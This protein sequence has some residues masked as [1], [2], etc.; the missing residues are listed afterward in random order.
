MSEQDQTFDQWCVV[1]LMGHQR[2]AGRIR[3]AA[4]PAG[5]VR[6]DVPATDGHEA[7]TQILNPASV[8]R[9][10]PTTEEIA[11]AVAANCRPAP[12]QRW[13][14]PTAAGERELES[15]G[16]HEPYGDGFDGGSF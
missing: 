9:L 16:H 3:P 15:V 6:L 8:Y 1:E 4:F 13:E 5:H 11:T 12:V 2:T 7:M 14:L 10:T